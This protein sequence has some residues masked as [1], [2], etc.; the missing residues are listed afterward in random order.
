MTWAGCPLFVVALLLSITSAQQPFTREGGRGSVAFRPLPPAKEKVTSD[1]DPECVNL[2]FRTL[3]GRC[4]SQISSALGEARRAQFSYF[5][6]SSV[7]P[8][9][10]DLPSARLISNIV[11]E[12][13][14]ESVNSGRL[15]ELFT[16][17]GQFIDHDFALTPLD[18]E[19]RLDIDIPADD[20]FLSS[21]LT[22]FRSERQ[23]ISEDSDKERPITLASSALDL[24]TVY[25]V[26]EERNAFLRVEGDCRLKTSGDNLLPLNTGGFVNSPNISPAFFIAGDTRSNE[27]PMLTVMHTIWV[28]EHNNVCDILES[29]P[30]FGITDPEELYQL[31]R[32]VT[33]AEYQKVVFDEWLPALLGSRLR[34]YRGY[35]PTVDPTISVEFTTSAFR[36]GHTLVGADVSRIDSRGNKL[37][38][39]P[40]AE[41]F[42]V[43]ASEFKSEDLDDFLRGAVQTRAQEFD[44]KVVDTLRNFLFEE[45][46][47]EEGFDLIALNL[48]RA[49]DHNVASFNV[50]RQFFLGSR[51]TSFA[52]ISNSA[53]ANLEAAYGDVDKVEAWIGLMAENKPRGAIV[54]P[55]L[56]ALLRTEF[57]RLRDGDQFFYKVADRVPDIVRE[58]YQRI[59][60]DIFSRSNIF[61]KILR[62]TSGVEARFLR[63][64]SNAFQ[65]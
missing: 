64:A 16:F 41:M 4:T 22:F 43:S 31:A 24:S 60:F 51:A 14:G 39:L 19:E 13:E 37:T 52:Q 30:D 62:R 34:R 63:G 61:N 12:Q 40:A 6:V 20:P 48:Q 17:F 38:P 57:E 9:G 23:K 25:G 58:T 54:G 2:R 18:E 45:V 15:N 59:N 42:F 53:A 35:N 55:T 36:L 11:S 1:P 47:E 65:N 56:N 29:N 26:E 44:E 32:L 3:S 46:P 10:E 21:P 33:I 28:R 27:T 50:L 7:E 5:D 8:S 49:R